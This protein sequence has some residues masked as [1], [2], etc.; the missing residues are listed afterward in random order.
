MSTGWIIG[1][2]I[3]VAIWIWITYEIFNA[4]LMP[5]D[6]ELKEEDIWPLD[7]RP[8]TEEDANKEN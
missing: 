4:P 8:D 3:F 2:V 6:F 1:I 7:E 5:D